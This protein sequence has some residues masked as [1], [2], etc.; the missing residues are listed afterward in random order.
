MLE[1]VVN[2]Y[3]LKECGKLHLATASNH[4]QYVLKMFSLSASMHSING[5]DSHLSKTSNF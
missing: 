4:L 1:A 2:C 5:T 3:V